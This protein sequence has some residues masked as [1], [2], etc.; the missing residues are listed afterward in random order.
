MNIFSTKLNEEVIVK[1]VVGH[2]TTR[3]YLKKLGIIKGVKISIVAH[4]IFGSILKVGDST[5]ALDSNIL[6]FIIT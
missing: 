6:K 4:T 2:S 3:K 5:I 1:D